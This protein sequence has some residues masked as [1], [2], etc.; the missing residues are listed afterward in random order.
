M[1][2]RMHARTRASFL[3]DWTVFFS[4]MRFDS[5]RPLSF[6]IRARACPAGEKIEDHGPVE[7][8]TI[9]EVQAEPYPLPAG[10]EWYTVDMTDEAQVDEVY[11]LLVQNYVED[12]DAMF[13][14]D[15]SRDFL[16]WYVRRTHMFHFMVAIAKHSRN[17][18]LCMFC[19]HQ[20]PSGTRLQQGVSHCR[21][22]RGQ[23]EAVWLYHW[24][25]RPDARL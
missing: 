13:R 24:C 7:T 11:N 22:R 25:P 6:L 12:S 8:K 10:F 23:Q 5:I 14:F 4:L 9:A 19:C 17:T 1:L 16:K 18:P 2:A 3:G 20:G 21:A 15:Y